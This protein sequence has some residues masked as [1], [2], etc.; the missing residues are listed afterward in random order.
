MCAR[1]RVFVC[2]YGPPCHQQPFVHCPL[3]AT[4]RTLVLVGKGNT[5]DGASTKSRRLTKGTAALLPDDVPGLAE[6]MRSSTVGEAR[7]VDI[8]AG[9]PAE[10]AELPPYLSPSMLSGEGKHV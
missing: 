9:E 4:S 10:P 8:D 3:T 2:V 7:V 1:A 6:F 5:N